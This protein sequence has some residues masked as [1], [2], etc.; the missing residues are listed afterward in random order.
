MRLPRTRCRSPTDRTILEIL[1]TPPLELTTNWPTYRITKR[2]ALETHNA[3]PCTDIPMRLPRT[4]CRS[5]TDR[6]ILEILIAI[7][8]AYSPVAD[9]SR[10]RR[11]K[12][13]SRAAERCPT[14]PHVPE[15][16]KALRRPEPVGEVVVEVPVSVRRAAVTFAI[17]G[18]K[19]SRIGLIGRVVVEARRRLVLDVDR[20]GAAPGVRVVEDV[21][22]AP[23]RIPREVSALGVD[24]ELSCRTVD[25]VLETVV[26]GVASGG[27]G[28]P[29]THRDGVTP[30]ARPRVGDEPLLLLQ[31]DQ[32]RLRIDPARHGNFVDDGRRGLVRRTAVA[33]AVGARRATRCR[34]PEVLQT[35]V[36]GLT[37]AHL[38]VE[39]IL[40]LAGRHR[41]RVEED[42]I[43]DDVAGLELAEIGGLDD[44]SAHRRICRRTDGCRRHAHVDRCSLRGGRARRVR[45]GD[46]NRAAQEHHG[47][48]DQHH[49]RART[50]HKGVSHVNSVTD[51]TRV[52]QA[53]RSATRRIGASHTGSTAYS[54]ACSC[55]TRSAWS[56]HENARPRSAERTEKRRRSSSRNT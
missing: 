1:I 27:I 37:R 33:V 43:A 42:R 55:H 46:E 47:H 52:H 40:D 5:P 29:L 32:Q 48:D 38:A 20:R 41:G 9:L 45:V 8:V 24:L 3:P 30:V 12:N 22:G 49:A 53:P 23:W 10:R 13:P 15:H 16:R 25:L 56:C 51:V 11:A 2:P 7:H 31:D 35:R 28:A 34:L 18:S 44:T 4:R 26:G 21:P 39:E 50:R 6:T 54:S 14:R 36:A 17:S 19:S